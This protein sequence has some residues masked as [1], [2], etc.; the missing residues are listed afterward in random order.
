MPELE[1]R[2][3]TPQAL[4]SLE[5][6]HDKILQSCALTLVF[7]SHWRIVRIAHNHGRRLVPPRTSTLARCRGTTYTRKRIVRILMVVM[8]WSRRPDTLRCI[9][10]I[11][12]IPAVYMTRVVRVC[13]A[14]WGSRR[15]GRMRFILGL[16]PAECGGRAGWRI[17]G[18]RKSLDN[19][20]ISSAEPWLTAQV[21]KFLRWNF[22]LVII[23]KV[24]LRITPHETRF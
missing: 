12:G 2:R 23:I 16:R 7:G 5:C 6:L 19:F 4:P 11:L 13:R 22:I 21:S 20:D 9:A 17:S 1:G 10:T 8:Q 15:R 3:T 14:C 18:G 24:V